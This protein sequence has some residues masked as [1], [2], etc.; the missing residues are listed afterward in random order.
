LLNDPRVFK[1]LKVCTKGI[2]FLLQSGLIPPPKTAYEDIYILGVGDKATVSTIKGEVDVKF[3][4]NFPF[5]NSNRL[6]SNEMQPDEELLLS[7][8]AE[9]T[10]SRCDASKP[11]FLFHSAGKDSN[12]IAL[13]LSEVGWQTNVTLVTHKSKGKADESQISA[14]IAKKLGFRHTVLHEVDR[15]HDRHL[16]EI[17]LYFRN[18][19]FPCTDNVAVA[20]PLYAQQLPELKQSNIIDGGGNDCYMMTPP[21]SRSLR[22]WKITKHT[23]KISFLRN[24]ISS[25][26]PITPLLRTPAEK[27]GMSGLSF[28]DTRNIFPE[29]INVYEFW[30]NESYI[31][32][33]WDLID[34]RTD[35]LTTITAAEVHIRKARNFADSIDSNLVLPFANSKVANYFAS[36]PECHVFSREKNKNKIILRNLLKSRVGIDSDKIGK[37]EYSYDSRQLI[38][39]NLK[40]FVAEIC[41]CKLWSQFEIEKLT[42]RLV[43]NIEQANSLLQSSCAIIYR[44]FTISAW[45]NR[46]LY[47]N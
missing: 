10:I 2:S 43:S 13:A 6:S 1:P 42:A 28:F 44:L 7:M 45:H 11:T 19:P 4:H 46:C 39:E 40:F 26:S 37:M 25:E 3:V 38:I 27:C 21:S 14:A 32:D 29:A 24:C 30:R 8:L 23:H 41:S 18:A 5:F 33:D 47:C 36:M 15:L 31:R 9:A 35:I 22:Y 20:Y 17:G 16:N 12:T 34:F